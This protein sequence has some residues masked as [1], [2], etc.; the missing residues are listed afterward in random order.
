VT[1]VFAVDEN[2][3]R[4]RVAFANSGWKVAFGAAGVFLTY[5]AARA[6]MRTINRATI[7]L[8]PEHFRR[9][10]INGIVLELIGIGFLLAAWNDGVAEHSIA[11][12]SWATP[13]YITE[14]ILSVVTGLLQW[15]KPATSPPQDAPPLPFDPNR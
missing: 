7:E 6:L 8:T 4:G 10:R 13:L 14:G 5:R 2:F 9:A 1:V 3:A 11:F 12:G 15:M